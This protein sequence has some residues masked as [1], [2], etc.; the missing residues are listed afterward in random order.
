MP[1]RI[2]ILV[3][4]LETPQFESLILVAVVLHLLSSCCDVPSGAR[5]FAAACGCVV[6]IVALVAGL[7]TGGLHDPFHLVAVSVRGLLI[8]AIV[9]GILTLIF[10]LAAWIYTCLCSCM[11]AP[12]RQRWTDR[13]VHRK[14]QSERLRLQEQ[15]LGKDDQLNP[16]QTAV[17]AS[18]LEQQR[19]EQCAQHRREQI[20][21]EV[22]LFFDRYRREL[23]D[24]FPEEK[25]DSY[26]QSFLTDTTAP[27]VFEQRAERLK[28]MIRDRLELSSRQSSTEFTSI[29]EVIAHYDGKRQLISQ[30]PVDD[31]VREDFL[32]QLDD[33]MERDLRE[34]L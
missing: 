26:F 22:R 6:I 24:V 32:M 23:A 31:E 8:A 33:S 16:E 34:F 17:A 30:L 18:E 3:D 14:Q 25:F 27:D 19:V 10:Q 28:D 1:N 15:R 21:F 7:L 4:F 9:T 13:Q 11:I 2:L 5:R 29:D 12:I 20:R